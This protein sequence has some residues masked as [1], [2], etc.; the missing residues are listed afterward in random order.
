MSA[1][2]N[3]NNPLHSLR[4]TRINGAE[5][6][7]KSFDIRGIYERLGSVKPLCSLAFGDFGFSLKQIF[8]LMRFFPCDWVVPGCIKWYEHSGKRKAK[9]DYI[10]AFSRMGENW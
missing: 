5:V 8:P 4:K 10:V 2:V 9:G 7:L 3:I 1:A 6:T